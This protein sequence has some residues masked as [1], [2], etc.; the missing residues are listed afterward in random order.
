MPIS[1]FVQRP[2]FQI[3]ELDVGFSGILRMRQLQADGSRRPLRVVSVRHFAAVVDDDEVVAV[4][5]GFDRVPLA[6]KNLHVGWRFGDI[7]DAAGQKIAAAV[8][9]RILI[10]NL[11]FIAWTA[12]SWCWFLPRRR[13]RLWRR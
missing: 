4:N 13:R 8:I 7:H 2:Q 11:Q 12:W 9:P 10:A 5:G 1:L 6:G 3:A